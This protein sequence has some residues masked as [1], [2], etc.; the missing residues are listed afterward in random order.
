MPDGHS[1]EFVRS[2]SGAYSDLRKVPSFCAASERWRSSLSARRF[3]LRPASPQLGDRCF[4]AHWQWWRLGRIDG[5]A[6]AGPSSPIKR[7]SR[8]REATNGGIA[9]ERRNLRAA[10]LECQ[11]ERSEEIASPATTRTRACRLFLRELQRSATTR[12]RSRLASTAKYAAST[13]VQSEA[14]SELRCFRTPNKSTRALQLTKFP[15][16]ARH[17]GRRWSHSPSSG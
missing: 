4:F 2:G 15:T 11:L 9:A 5:A 8:R 1:C 3:D 10:Y 12:D 6:S 17:I 7:P 13:P 16:P 14:R